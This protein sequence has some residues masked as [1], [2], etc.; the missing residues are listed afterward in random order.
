[1]KTST[2]F[3]PC[4]IVG[5]VMSP[6]AMRQVSYLKRMARWEMLTKFYSRN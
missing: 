5:R 4:I 1:M 3:K 2:R 6:R